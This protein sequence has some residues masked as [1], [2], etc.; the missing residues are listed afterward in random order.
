MPRARAKLA[1]ACLAALVLGGA[2]QVGCM[3]ITSPGDFRVGDVSAPDA[4][5]S[6]ASAA[7][8]SVGCV[9]PST[10]IDG[11]D[12]VLR[13]CVL[14]ESC[15]PK[16]VVGELTISQ[17]ATLNW[18]GV[19]PYTR[20]ASAT[21][22]DA[23]NGCIGLNPPQNGFCNGAASTTCQGNVVVLCSGDAGTPSYTLD[24]N[25]LGGRCYADDAGADGC[26]VEGG[27]CTG[28]GA[29]G[30]CENNSFY[31]C[32]DGVPVGWSC[33]L[34]SAICTPGGCAVQRPSCDPQGYT[35]NGTSLNHCTSQG[36]DVS[37]CSKMGL[38]CAMSDAGD[39]LCV[40]PGCGQ[41]DYDGCA[42]SCAP[43][44]VHATVCIGGARST[45]DC[46]A[47]GFTK[48]ELYPADAGSTNV[49]H[50]KCAP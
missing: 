20:C 30:A 15:P 4:G 28:G 13:T 41:S 50:V 22:C 6:D 27:T 40:A 29:S 45:I 21:T 43:D 31:Q 18:P 1:F 11:R 12:S 48:C 44:G 9:A 17:C 7:E 33:N 42:E 49:P 16:Y 34:F 35:C 39:G 3:L 36:L 38:G 10:T 5:G 2:V 19:I 37:D 47:Y 26:Q 23:Y 14:M 32:K 25:V 24:C 8:A 46:S